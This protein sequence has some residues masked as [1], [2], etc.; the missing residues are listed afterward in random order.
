MPAMPIG[1]PISPVAKGIARPRW[2]VMIPT[3][4][5][6]RT[7]PSTIES[8]LVQ[9]PAPDVM[10]I[11]VVDD[12]SREDIAGVVARYGGRVGFHR[13][14]RNLGVPENLTA[15]IRLSRGEIVHI[16]HGDDRVKPGFYDAMSQAMEA[17][18]VGAAFCRQIF[19]DSTGV[20]TAMSPL[21]PA[22]R[23]VI[24]DAL[25]FLAAEQRVM[26]PSICVRRSVYELLGGFHPELRCSEDWEMWV[27]IA[28]CF[29]VWYETEPLAVYRVQKIS[30]T[31]RNQRTGADLDFTAHAIEIMSG[32][33]PA[34]E[35][36]SAARRTRALYARS[37][38]EVAEKAA[39]QG[40]LETAIAQW[41]GA[42]RLS[43]AAGVLP[44]AALAA[45]RIAIAAMPWRRSAAQT[46]S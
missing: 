1:P 18:D 37:A 25:R 6:A 12:A 21:D 40:D 42:L 9:A 15:C 28:S 43:R 4:E 3:Y 13:Q 41:R 16:L 5:C 8:V 45:S 14:S 44:R 31:S 23:G 24:P 17:A 11:V 32:Y 35:R 20:E 38:L 34:A 46:S 27:R 36:D 19:V 26:T 2:S 39:Q 7:L 30:N 10:E 33:L 22:R 29:A